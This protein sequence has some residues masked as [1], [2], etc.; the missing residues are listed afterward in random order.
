MKKLFPL[1]IISMLFF[2]CKKDEEKVLRS[3]NIAVVQLLVYPVTNNGNTWDDFS[4]YPD[5]YFF[6]SRVNSSG[7]EFQ[8]IV[9]DE[10][11]QNQANWATD[12]V[13]FADQNATFVF[14]D[15]DGANDDLIDSVFLDLDELKKNG[16]PTEFILYGSLGM[17]LKLTIDYIFK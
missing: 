1:I 13:C 16:Y 2:S 11:H 9:W 7:I 12:L 8:S 14:F 6:F 15:E 10:A 3:L 17:Q 4:S 5:P